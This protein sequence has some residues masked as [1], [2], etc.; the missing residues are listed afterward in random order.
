MI[1]FSIQYTQAVPKRKRGRRES[2]PFPHS[3]C[4]C[5]YPFVTT[6]GGG[7]AQPAIVASVNTAMIARA[8]FFIAGLPVR[9]GVTIAARTQ[10]SSAEK[11]HRT[12]IR[13][14]PLAACQH[15]RREVPSVRIRITALMRNPRNDSLTAMRVR[16][17]RR[18][19]EGVDDVRRRCAVR[20]CAMR[21]SRPGG[22]ASGW[23]PKASG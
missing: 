20:R 17:P 12:R 6:G 9:D 21:R 19:H 8:S 4:C 13:T 22:G 1:R 23:R 7:V 10:S 11:T 18:Q 16:K 15:A 2:R 3:A 5:H 14:A